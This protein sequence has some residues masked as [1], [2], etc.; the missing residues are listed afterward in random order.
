MYVENRTKIAN[1]PTPVYLTPP[2]KGFPVEFGIGVRG[3]KC[4][5]DGPIRW[6][7]KFS[8]RFS[9]FD[10]IPAVT[11]T[12]Q[13]PSLPPSHVAVAIT[14]NAK[15]SSL[16]TFGNCWC[17]IF[18]QIECRSRHQTNSSGSVCLIWTQN[19]D[20]NRRSDYFQ[21]K[22]EYY[23]EFQTDLLQGNN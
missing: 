17:D 14:L 23:V 10:T 11:D 9:R 5:N 6:S 21:S 19:C 18:L 13:P 12:S 7:K 22:T 3:S 2:M 1:F 8:D 15:A 4:L 16:K 20:Q